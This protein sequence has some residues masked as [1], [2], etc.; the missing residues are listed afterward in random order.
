MSKATDGNARRSIG[1]ISMSKAMD[2]N[3]YLEH[4]TWRDVRYKKLAVHIFIGT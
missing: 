4:M 3:A 2:G 1:A